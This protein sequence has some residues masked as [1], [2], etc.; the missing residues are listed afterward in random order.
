MRRL[1][2]LRP[3]PGASETVERARALGLDARAM[4][5][6]EVEPVAW[7]PPDATAF[8]ALLLTS[9]NA[10]RH[11]GPGLQA[12]RGLPVHAVGEATAVAARDA[13]FDIRSTGNDG[14]ERLV[15]S[16]EQTLRLLHLC[17]EHRHHVDS[18]QEIAAIP[19][20]R[21][22]ALPPPEPLAEAQGATVA[23]HSSRAAT[24]FSELA[25]QASLDRA[26]IRIAA[27]SAAALAAA[28]DGWDRSEAADRPTDDALLAVAARLCEKPARR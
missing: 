3:E 1:I 25:S 11:G 14:A 24:R 5:L 2:V 18:R 26:T 15:G 12:L 22:E 27:I 17:G 10:V 23:V 6:F 20:Y 28:G 4:P 7:Q 9:A 8:D 16:I 13:G 19:V 21:S